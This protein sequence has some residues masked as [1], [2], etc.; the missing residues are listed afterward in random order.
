MFLISVYKICVVAILRG[1][2]AGRTFEICN[3]LL[4]GSKTHAEKYLGRMVFLYKRDRFI[5]AYGIKVIGK[6]RVKAFIEKP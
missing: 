3:I 1:G 6:T 5:N 4:Y 2:T